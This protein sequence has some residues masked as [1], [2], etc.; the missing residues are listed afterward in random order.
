MASCRK[1]QR[2]IPLYLLEELTRD[3]MQRVEE[4]LKDCP[5]C[6]RMLEQE[7][8]LHQLLSSR[9]ELV[10]SK[11]LLWECR[12]K[13]AGC[14]LRE[15]SRMSPGRQRV[16]LSFWGKLK[17]LSQESVSP[18]W[19]FAVGAACLVL[20]LLLGYVVWRPYMN[21]QSDAG[22]TTIREPYW[23]GGQWVQ[24]YQ[25]WYSPDRDIYTIDLAIRE[26]IFGPEHPKM[27][28]YLSS[29]AEFYETQGKYAKAEPLY[30]RALT[31]RERTL[32]S[33]HPEVAA[34]L[35]RMASFYD[36][37]GKEDEA[38]RLEE[39]AKGIRSRGSQ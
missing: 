28:A 20:G 15:V 5:D 8:A 9:R 12:S 36:R 35:E 18:G 21:R 2:L 34:M 37:I 3:E 27:A 10:P 6:R 30:G 25:L 17:Q 23:K 29:L 14:L 16:K 19:A 38:R 32:G 11:E 24:I 39:R 26:T 13:L 31:I 4:H 7:K 1:Y 33:N 22:V